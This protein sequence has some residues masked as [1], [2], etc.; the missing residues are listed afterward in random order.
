MKE[1]LPSDR[2]AQA[3]QLAQDI[4]RLGH[5]E[6]LQIARTLLGADD[7]SLF[8]DNEF[9]VRDLIHKVAAK[10]YQQRL[11]RKKTATRAPQ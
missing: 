1:V 3:E 2:E 9:A 5:D 4:A 11:A 6:L 8:G 10:A 7:A